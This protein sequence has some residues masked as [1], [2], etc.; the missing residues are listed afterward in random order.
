MCPSHCLDRRTSNS[1]FSLPFDSFPEPKI[2]RL[3]EHFFNRNPVTSTS[4][5]WSSP[6]GRRIREDLRAAPSHMLTLSNLVPI[7]SSKSCSH[8]STVAQESISRL[9][10]RFQLH[11]YEPTPL[12]Q[13]TECPAVLARNRAVLTQR[14]AFISASRVHM[15]SISQWS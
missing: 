9:P 7:P 5:Q 6:P 4:S 10:I 2:F 12:G 8:E 13:P 15:N 1:A 11:P 14:T 3:F